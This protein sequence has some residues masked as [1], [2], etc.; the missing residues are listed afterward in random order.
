M[1]DIPLHN[2][3]IHTPYEEQAESAATALD[4]DPISADLLARA[5]LDILA[6]ATGADSNL[7]LR[8][9]APDDPI[10]HLLD[11]LSNG[12]ARS[13]QVSIRP[14]IAAVAILTARALQSVPGLVRELRR[15]NPVVTI[16]TNSADIVALV[17]EVMEECAF[18]SDVQTFRNDQYVTSRQH[19]TVLTFVRDGTDTG[20]RPEKGNETVASALH[21]QSPIIGIAPDPRRHLPR[22][23]MRTAEHHLVLGELDESAVALVVEVVTGRAPRGAIAPELISALDTSDLQLAVRK[24]LTPDQCVTRLRELVGSKNILD[25]GGGPRLEEL[26]GYGLAKDWG[27]R[28]AADL[29]DFRRGRL[30]WASIDKGLLLEGP[31]GVGKTQYA[32]A[33]ARTAGVPFLATSVA[34]WNSANY[35]SGTLQTMRSVFAQAR[36]LAPSIIFIDELDGISDR[37]RLTGEYVEYWSQIVNL[38][39]ELLSGAEDRPG[40]VVLAATN[41]LDRI[42]PAIR[43]AGRL[44]RTITIAR[45][46]TEDLCEI[47]RYHLKNDLLDADV[48]PLALAAEGSTGADVDAWVRRGR[49]HAR[50]AARDL[51][52]ADILHEIRGQSYVLPPAV[53]RIVT[54]HEAGHIVVGAA[55]RCYKPKRVWLTETGGRASGE[56]D[57]CGQLTLGGLERIITMILAGRAAEKLFLGPDEITIGASVGDDSDL[58]RATQI[59]Y[60]I[61]TRFG[62][63]QY[64]LTHFPENARQIIMHDKAVLVAIEERLRRCHLEAETIIQHN[65]AAVLAIA[66]RL[67]EKG[68]VERI[69]LTQILQ[70][71]NLGGFC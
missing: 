14:D 63:G 18:G 70:Q 26:S 56:S 9:G 66:A 62:F 42:D 40:V 58:A 19:R 47:F 64:G 43:R 17:A 57:I 46:K 53:E 20:H 23:L 45:P 30:D 59:A 25:D 49:S 35:L 3:S 50:R 21:S 32:K 65:Q 69:E 12:S 8:K 48:M 27:L 36:K 34:D 28:L 1:S 33:L 13:N 41:H 68:Y 60:D 10:E 44:D 11:D 15:G 24:W 7:L 6:R 16:A 67:R 31:T 39:L 37:A 55:L 22:D 5:F 71:H 2:E 38:L 51:T 52:A 4:S 54:L 61:E 29:A